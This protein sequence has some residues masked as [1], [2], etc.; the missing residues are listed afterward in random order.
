MEEAA[1]GEPKKR[2]RKRTK[3][4]TAASAFDSILA[5]EKE[6]VNKRFA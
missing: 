6:K 4:L 1:G 5:P 2:V 3:I